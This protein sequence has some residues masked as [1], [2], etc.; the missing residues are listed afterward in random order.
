LRHVQE[1]VMSVG[2]GRIS[3]GL[4]QQSIEQ[5]ANDEGLRRTFL[6]TL[7]GTPPA[8]GGDW[9]DFLRN[10][11]G[12]DRAAESYV[13]NE[14]MRFW[15]PEYPD[16][17]PD[18][19]Q[20]IL[21]QSLIKAIELANSLPTDDKMPMP[22]DCHWIWTDNNNKFEALITSSRRQVT[23][24]LLTPPPPT[25]LVLPLR[26]LAPYFIVKL[27]PIDPAQEQEQPGPSGARVY[28]EDPRVVTAQL[29]SVR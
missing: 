27:G 5:V 18:I 1:D 3:K 24:I 28:L 8:E 7:Q 9:I 16:Y 11:G 4:F 12:L 19:V 29:K 25:D 17:S 15:Q 2:F 23:R 20:E 22:I 10:H 26:F 13:R 6:D 21:R 14:W